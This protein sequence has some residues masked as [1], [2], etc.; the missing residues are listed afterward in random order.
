VT[1]SVDFI[2]H[3]DVA[4]DEPGTPATL[5]TLREWLIP[6]LLSAIRQVLGAPG[7][8]DARW[9]GDP[10]RPNYEVIILED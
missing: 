6:D 10:R 2:L 1:T 8:Y 5:D 9:A 3:L 7:D 4:D